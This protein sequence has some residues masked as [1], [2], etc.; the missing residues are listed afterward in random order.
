MN[1]KENAACFDLRQKSSFF[2]LKKNV[3]SNFSR[4]S[5]YVSMSLDE[6]QRRFEELQEDDLDNLSL[7]D[8]ERGAPLVDDDGFDPYSRN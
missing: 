6:I 5:S 7:E 1:K 8:S 2:F 3:M 4:T